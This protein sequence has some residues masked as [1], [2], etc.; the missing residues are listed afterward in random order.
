MSE[1]H[2]GAHAREPD[3]ARLDAADQHRPEPPAAPSREARP[4]QTCRQRRP[5]QTPPRRT[6]RASPSMPSAAPGAARGTGRRAG[7]RGRARR[8]GAAGPSPTHPHEPTDTPEPAHP[9]PAPPPAASGHP[10][11][12]ATRTPSGGAASTPTARSTSAPR[13]VSGRSAPGRPA[14]PPRASPTSRAASTTC[15]PRPSCWSAGCPR[16]APTPST[17]WPAHAPCAT[18]WPR[19]TSSATSWG[20][21]RCST[22]LVA[23][24]EQAVGAQRAERDAARVAA[25]ARKEALAAE[26]ETLAAEATQWKQAGDRFKAILDEWRT[27]RGIDRKTD[28]LLW[29]R[30]SKAREAFNRRRGSH[31]ADLDR[32]RAGARA[33]KEELALEAEKLADSDDWGPTAARFR[34]LMTE[35]KAAGRAQKDADDALWQRF[36]TAQDALLR[37][38]VA[39]LR[40]ARRRVRRERRR[41]SGRCSTRPRRST[42]AIRTPPAPPCAASRS[43]GRRSARCPRDDIR[44]AGGADAGRRGEGPRG[45]RPRSGGA[46][47][48]RPRRGSPSSAS[49]WRSS[50]RRRPRPA[51]RATPGA[52]SR[53]QAP[54]R[55]VARVAGDRGAGRPAPLTPV[56]LCDRRIVDRGDI[57]VRIRRRFVDHGL[58]FLRNRHGGT[59]SVLILGRMSPE[60][61]A[62]ADP[63]TAGRA[64]HAR[65][66]RRPR[67]LDADRA[68]ASP[69]QAAGNVCCPASSSSPGTAQRRGTRAGG[70]AVG[71]RAR[72]GV[73]PPPPGGTACGRRCPAPSR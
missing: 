66:G 9:V 24:A 44:A 14:S 13:T 38:P 56:F 7:Q 72:R 69:M 31:F 6:S 59:A 25:V 32:Q 68:A 3:G 20:W 46:R 21:P 12:P 5:R 47:I 1:Q 50:R 71:R 52:P 34:D 2:P 54:G 16:A 22:A 11:A 53:P 23:Q 49:A 48:P 51:P 62:R 45:R 33:R 29:K 30:F 26:A 27:V 67:C 65:P 70:R 73:G 10:V 4:R 28:E 8:R 19:R 57:A 17:R 63:A 36:R 41:R 40:R 61:R 60:G 58:G 55:P 15:S 35:W 64:G 18:A 39:E 37:P 42:P 43:A